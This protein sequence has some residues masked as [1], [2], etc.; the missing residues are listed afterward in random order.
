MGQ[1]TLSG[2]KVGQV[3]SPSPGQGMGLHCYCDFCEAFDGIFYVPGP[4]T[5]RLPDSTV[6]GYKVH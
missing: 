3:S 4:R 5:H 6:S 1:E 2:C